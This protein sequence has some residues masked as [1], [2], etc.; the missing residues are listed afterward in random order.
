MWNDLKELNKNPGIKVVIHTTDTNFDEDKEK[1]ENRFILDLEEALDEAQEIYLKEKLDYKNY[2]KNLEKDIDET[3]VAIV[4]KPK[5]PEVNK[6]REELKRIFD[7]S[8][9]PPGE[10]LIQ[11]SLEKTNESN[12]DISQVKD[13]KYCLKLII[14]DDLVAS[15][16]FLDFD[17]NYEIC[18]NVSYTVKLTTKIPESIKI[19]IHEQMKMKLNSKLTQ[20][21]IPIPEP[22]DLHDEMD[23]INFEFSTGKNDRNGTIQIKI[24]WVNIENTNVSP[25]QRQQKPKN[26]KLSR[27]MVKKWYDDQILDPMDPD[28]KFLIDLMNSD[29]PI[30][31]ENEEKTK[32]DDEEK[33]KGK[34]YFNEDIYAF[35]TAEEINNNKRF[36][37]LIERF[38]NN[39]RFKNMK[40]IPQ[41]ERYKKINIILGEKFRK[42][43]K[44]LAE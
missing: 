19:E 15:T 20:I 21:F 4:E 44:I 39:L 33:E 11:I 10:P 17:G 25:I 1:F 32:N 13:V 9:R 14:D 5:K 8:F 23:F 18:F 24:G 38:N 6:I 41:S 12:E 27:E 36:N 16:K 35:C 7:E 43:K 34:F 22:C 42:T 2:F 30:L 31:Q 40:F 3:E 28:S 26:V 29:K 37:M